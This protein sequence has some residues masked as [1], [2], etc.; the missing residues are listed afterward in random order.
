M[1]VPRDARGVGVE[2]RAGSGQRPKFYRHSLKGN[3]I[4]TNPQVRRRGTNRKEG[5]QRNLKFLASKR[6]LDHGRC[7]AEEIPSGNYDHSYE[8]QNTKVLLQ[9]PYPECTMVSMP[10]SKSQGNAK[11]QKVGRPPSAL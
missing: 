6:L 9:S 4:R 11:K 10:S 7:F 3:L 5:T 2:G 1:T 8:R